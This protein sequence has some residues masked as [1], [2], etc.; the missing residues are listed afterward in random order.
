MSPLVEP[1]TISDSAVA[2]VN[3]LYAYGTAVTFCLGRSCSVLTTT[4]I[5]LSPLSKFD[6]SK[7]RRTLNAPLM[8]GVTD[9][10]SDE[11]GVNSDGPL[12]RLK[13]TGIGPGTGD[14]EELVNLPWKFI[15]CV[16]GYAEIE[17][18]I[19]SEVKINKSFLLI[20]ISFISRCPELYCII[21][22]KARA[23]SPLKPYI[24]YRK[25]R[26]LDLLT[27]RPPALVSPPAYPAALSSLR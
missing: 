25:R 23:L 17:N 6:D 2:A 11:I 9:M 4:S 22:Q 12:Y 24:L 27:C 26:N 16:N 8:S 15:C 14:P 13:V 21:I 7:P 5:H 10:D 18:R 20:N 19:R 3:A 1:D